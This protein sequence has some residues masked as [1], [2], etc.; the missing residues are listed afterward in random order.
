[1]IAEGDRLK[2]KNP[3]VMADDKYGPYVMLLV[4]FAIPAIIFYC[5]Y[6]DGKA[7]RQSVETAKQKAQELAAEIESLENRLMA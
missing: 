6:K 1:M 4:L 5:E 2:K 7:Y 3:T